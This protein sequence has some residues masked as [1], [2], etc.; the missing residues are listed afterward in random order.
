VFFL[1]GLIC[2]GIGAWYVRPLQRTV[3]QSY[4]LFRKPWLSFSVQVFAF[5]CAFYGGMQLPGKVFPKFTP[6]KFEG[7]NHSYYTS[8]Q[9]IV[10]KFRLFETM[11]TQDSQNDVASYL[12]VYSTQPLTKNEMMDNLALH[13]LKEFDLGKMF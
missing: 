5:T 6:S 1:L 3:S 2:G 13:A 8:S 11:E 7:V 12:S 4:P 9:D 10:S